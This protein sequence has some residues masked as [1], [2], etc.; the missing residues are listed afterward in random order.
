M[1]LFLGVSIRRKSILIELIL[2][3]V[4]SCAIKMIESLLFVALKRLTGFKTVELRLTTY[5]CY[6]PKGWKGATIRYL[7]NDRQWEKLYAGLEIF[8]SAMCD[9]LEPDLVERSAMREFAPA[10]SDLS[11][12][13]QR[14]ICSTH[15][16]IR[17]QFPRG[18]G[19]R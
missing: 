13:E 17:L 16:I 10:D 7:I 4:S 3:K 18:R 12:S 2:W 9:A 14:H 6:S 11:Q 5:E 8:L 1:E 19:T 15:R